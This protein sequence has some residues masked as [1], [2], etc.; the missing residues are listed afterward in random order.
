M[1]RLI[2]VF[3]LFCLIMGVAYGFT[4]HEESVI[5]DRDFKEIIGPK[6][7][8][9]PLVRFSSVEG[10]MFV[11]ARD[12][13]TR[14][15]E[16]FL[17]NPFTR[18]VVRQGK[19]PFAAFTAS[20]IS[21]LA[22]RVL[23]F[24]RYPTAIWSLDLGS[25]NW[26]RLYENTK[27]K[28]LNILSIS[29]LEYADSLW[30]YTILDQ[31]DEEG[32]VVDTAV[33]AMI[34][35]PFTKLQMVTL[36]ELKDLAVKLAV[37][38]GRV[39]SGW[40]YHADLLTFGPDKS[41]VFI[42]KSKGRGRDGKEVDYLMRLSDNKKLILLDKSEGRLF[43]MDHAGT[44]P[45]V[46]YRET[47]DGNSQLKMWKEGKITVIAND[48]VISAKLLDD[49][50]VAYSAVKGASMELYMGKPGEKFSRLMTLKQP[51]RVG[52][53]R[54]GRKMILMSRNEIKCFRI[55]K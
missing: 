45:A 15:L 34:P 48:K 38:G 36:R 9:M 19:C 4:A 2:L 37:G 31:R 29:P 10:M 23:A 24:S 8:S 21:P 53:M 1:K 42:L 32:F 14:D 20:T 52:F 16:W 33:L 28:G 40:R 49:G 18:R 3:S 7:V 12:E 46:L 55:S 41:L 30:A 47:V 26:T 50:T 22:N 5:T 44:P 43:P 27:G 39:P 13:A 17:V 51:Y 11:M 6:L 54:S 35:T 25:G